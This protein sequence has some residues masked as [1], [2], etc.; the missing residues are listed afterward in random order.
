MAANYENLIEPLARYFWGEPNAQLST[1][2]KIFFG[3]HGSKSV[4]LVKNTFFDHEANVGGGVLKLLQFALGIEARKD[5]HQWLVDN[6]FQGG[7]HIKKETETKVIEPDPQPAKPSPKIVASYDYRD[8]N[9]DL[10]MQVTRLEPKTFRQRQPDGT[11]WNWSVKG[12]RTVPYRLPELIAAPGA[13]VYIV[14]GEKDADRLA[15]LGLVATCNAGG[16]GKW[17]PAHADFLRA[18]R[19]IVLPDNDPAGVKHG[20]QVLTSLRGIAAET[21][22]IPLPGLP[23]KG[24]VSDWLD[25]G[26]SKEELERLCAAP[27]ARVAEDSV[28]V[29][30]DETLD[31]HRN[32]PRP[33]PACLYGLVGDVARAG[34]DTTEANPF[35]VA[36]NFIAFMGCAIGRG[37]YM[38]IGNTWHHPRMFVLHIGRSGRGRKGDAVSLISRIERA[39]KALNQEATPQ[40]HRGGLSSREGLV[41]LI[42]DG[43][44][45]GKTEV[46]PVHDKRLLV[47]E[48]EFANVL[49]QSKREG[50]T[51]SAALRDCWDGVSMKPA[52]KSSRL[53]A[54]D[55]HVSIVGAVTPS[56]LL[57]LMESRELTNGFANRFLMFWA[58]RSKMLAFPRATRQED[59]DALAQRVLKVLQFCQSERWVDKD[60]TRVELSQE[61][62][63]RYEVLYH[64]ELNDNSAG[65][66]ITALIERRAPML[67]RLAMLFALCDLT[68]TVEVRHIDA[69]LAWVRF[70]VDS[71]KFIFGSAADEVAVAETNESAEKIIAFVKSKNRVT[72]K[73]ITVECFSGHVSKTRID[74]ALDELLSANPPRIVVEEDRSGGGR[75]TK[76]YELGAK[77]ANKANFQQPRGFAGDFGVCALS[78]LKKDSELSQSLNSQVRKVR[79]VPKPLETRAS[80]AC[81]LN[82]LNSQ[83]NSENYVEVDL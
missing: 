24:D 46:D 42:H 3:T 49:I 1:P 44:K 22:I 74:A 4:D 32:A 38:P 45:E 75:P 58:E 19:V 27:E 30:E 60:H 68:S 23:E 12:V 69:A 16:A 37:P 26:G 59:V 31:N 70:G 56:E 80:A 67:L 79:E 65:E 41:Y 53:W 17:T 6:G 40:V 51:L 78:E 43:F 29:E 11:G 2:E 66:K 81:S 83:H 15:S 14:E 33:D 39:L 48:S 50:N 7:K 36:A 10:L 73:Q 55:P 35:A 18:R 9:G 77:Y 52:T 54:T 25:A 21:R 47:I 5:A 57:G 28:A 34:G 62:R 13:T 82:S 76:F 8:E 61:A 72:R 63:S 20:K 64:S 71:V